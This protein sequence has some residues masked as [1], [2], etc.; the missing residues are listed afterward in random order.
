MNFNP[1]PLFFSLFLISFPLSLSLPP[2]LPSS[3]SISLLISFFLVRFLAGLNYVDDPKIGFNHENSPTIIKIITNYE[4]SVIG[5]QPGNHDNDYVNL[6]IDPIK[7]TLINES[8]DEGRI[9]SVRRD[10]ESWRGCAGVHA[11]YLEWRLNIGSRFPAGIPN[12]PQEIHIITS[13]QLFN[14]FIIDDPMERAGA[15]LL[16]WATIG[17]IF[18]SGKYIL[19]TSVTEAC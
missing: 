7:K 13:R 6:Y 16:W 19:D 3:L 5:N 15:V 1:L 9:L 4:E 14:T 17:I 8:W 12:L 10:M 18:N 11:K 2:S